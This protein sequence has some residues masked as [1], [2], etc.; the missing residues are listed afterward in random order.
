MQPSEAVFA[1][2]V[3]DKVVV[4]AVTFATASK[5]AQETTYLDSPYRIPCRFRLIIFADDTVQAWL[6]L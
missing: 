6:H 5:P 3:Q 1:G 4:L 2:C